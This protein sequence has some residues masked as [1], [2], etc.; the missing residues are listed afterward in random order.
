MTA[1]ATSSMNQPQPTAIATA[2][3]ARVRC[4]DRFAVQPGRWYDPATGRWMSQDPLGFDAGDSNLYRYVA[5]KPTNATDSS[6]LDSMGSD[7]G[8]EG[9]I[10]DPSL[11]PIGLTSGAATT[12]IGGVIAMVGETG[13][14]DAENPPPPPTYQYQLQLQLQPVY[15]PF[16]RLT[17]RSQ[18]VWVLV[19]VGGV[20]TASPPGI[21]TTTSNEPPQQQ[22][23]P[24]GKLNTPGTP[25]EPPGA[26]M[27]IPGLPGV[28]GG[29]LYQGD[30]RGWRAIGG[31]LKVEYGPGGPPGPVQ[32]VLKIIG[33]IFGR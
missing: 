29:F 15:G 18:R 25:D 19:Q 31:T 12:G 4:R 21:T 11:M 17:W 33:R 22:Q 13:A 26:T 10:S 32:K 27:N 3:R 2:G 16:G 5:N 24:K 6:G 8:F 9:P 28:Q 20:S 7:S 23:P 14:N 1:S 30:T